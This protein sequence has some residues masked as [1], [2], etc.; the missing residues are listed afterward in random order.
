[1][2]ALVLSMI[3]IYSLMAFLNTQRTQEIGVRMALGAGRWQV[4]RA[5]TGRAIGITVVGT[6]IGSLLAIGAG[7]AM[8]SVLYGMVTTSFVQLGALVVILGSV[9]LLAS[10]LPARRAARIDPMAALRQS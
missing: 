10:Y 9:A 4:V 3:G 1:V 8:E 7:R 5:M 6:V 2:I